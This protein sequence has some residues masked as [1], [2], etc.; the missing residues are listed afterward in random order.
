MIRPIV[1]YRFTT[2]PLTL[3]LV[4]STRGQ[5]PAQAS[6]TV[7]TMGSVDPGEVGE[8]LKV[9]VGC[10]D[11]AG[12]AKPKNNEAMVATRALAMELVQLFKAY[13][14]HNKMVMINPIPC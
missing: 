11:H 3:E 14:Q 7:M 12:G 9:V 6:L 13:L 4:E 10:C 1:T 2:R 5:L 8:K